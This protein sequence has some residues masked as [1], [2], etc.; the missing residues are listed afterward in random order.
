MMTKV[1][2]HFLSFFSKLRRYCKQKLGI[3]NTILLLSFFTGVFGATAAII[4]K[5]LLH[6]TA[7][8]LTNAFPNAEHNYLYLAFP[9][10]GI[11]ITIVFVTRVVKDDISHGVS[12]VL[13]AISKDN[14]KLKPH[15]MY[16]SMVASSITVGFGG[17]V[18]LEAPMVLTGSA[19]GSNV[20][21]YF[22]MSPKNTVLLLAC[23]CTAAFAAVFKAP[24][25]ALVFAIE[26]LMI[27]FTAATVLPLMISAATGIVLSILFM[28]HNVMFTA[29]GV[30]IFDVKNVP[31]YILLGVF[32]AFVSLYFLRTLRTIEKWFSKIKRKYLKGILGGLLLGGLIFFFPMFYGEGYIYI[33]EIL[34]SNAPELIFKNSPLHH[35]THLPLLFLGLILAVILLKVIATAVTTASGGVGGTFAPALFIGG[36]CGFFVSHCFNVFFGLQLPYLHFILAGMA[37]I[38]SGVMLTPLTAI[39]LTAELSTGYTLLIPLMI[40]SSISYLIVS[41]IEKYSLYGKQL[42]EK[43]ELKTHNKDFFAM[44]KVDW[45]TLIDHDI[46]TIPI[47]STLREYI[48]IISKSTRNLFVVVDENRKFVG[49]LVMDY[50][51]ETI[52]DQSKYDTVFVEELMIEPEEFVYENDSTKTVIEKFKRTGNYNLPIV[53]TDRTYIGFLSRAKVL[54]AYRDFIAEESNG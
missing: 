10:L 7:S 4:I 49:L 23:G 45:R 25:A 54:T 13:S 18:G 8:S 1:T 31:Y 28:G 39:F 32:T 46:A 9:L 35:F 15:N 44:K 14:G 40:T 29:T 2:R 51:R 34:S 12:R 24:I 19:I 50:H 52:F 37:G 22:N 41:P 5:N 16:S 21:R 27:D 20:A 11:I 36:F 3:S 42:A 38:M 48:R 30:T 43:G 53:S 6:F 17:S 47:H 26:L 33:N